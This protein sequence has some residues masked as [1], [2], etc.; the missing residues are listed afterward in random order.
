MIPVS[1]PKRIHHRIIIDEVSVFFFLRI[2]AGMKVRLSLNRFGDP[3]IGRQQGV[4]P[5]GQ[6]VEVPA[7][8]DVAMEHLTLGMHPGVGAAAA[9]NCCLGLQHLSQ[10]RFNLG[11]HGDFFR[12]YLPTHKMRTVIGNL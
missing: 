9:V 8:R 12:L 2:E 11:L 3:D 10:G 7:G 5:I 4:D 6:F 1:A